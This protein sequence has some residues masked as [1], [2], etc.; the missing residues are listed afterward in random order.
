[1]ARTN[2]LR[3]G[4]ALFIGL[5]AATFGI[6]KISVSE[7]DYFDYVTVFSN[8][9]IARFTEMPIRVYISPML[10]TDVYL[11]AIRY[12]MRQWELAAG[13]II[14]FVETEDNGDADIRVSWGT[15]GLWPITEVTGAKA[16]LTRLDGDRIRV[17]IILV[18]HW[19][20]FEEVGEPGRLRAIC[21]HE[22]G[23]A[24]GL[25]G[26]S[27][28]SRDVEFRAS[29]LEHPS[30]RDI[31]T[32]RRVYATP[33]NTPQHEIAIETINQRLDGSPADARRHYL[34]GT[35]TVDK[36]DF[37]EAI[38]HFKTALALDPASE[39]AR[40]K[41]LQVYHDFGHYEQAI[42]LVKE[43]LAETPSHDVYN[44]LGVMFYRN[45]QID[46]SI[47]AFQNSVDRNSHDLAAQHNLHQIFREKG[48]AALQAANY[49]QA[50]A[51]FEK[52]LHY[53]ARD[54]SAVYRLMGDSYER[55]GEF[56]KAISHY[57][58]A[59]ETNPVNRE[60]QDALAQ[61]HNN[62]GVRLRNAKRWDDAINAYKR[63]LALAPTLAVARSN[64]IDALL[65][66]AKHH[67]AMGRLDAAIATYRELAALET[68]SSDAHSRLGE[69]YLEQEAYIKAIESFQSAYDLKPNLPQTRHNLVVAYSTYAKHLDTQSR[70]DHAIKQL[71]QALAVAPNHVNLHVSLARVYQ[72]SGDF[73]RA[74]AA[75]ARAL[76]IQPN[77]D[78]VSRES[79]SLRTIRAN[80]LLNARRYSAAL[81]E[82]EAIPPPERSVEIHN[83]IGYLYL[84]RRGFAKAVG[85]FESA[86]TIAPTNLI[87][88]QN[89]LAIESQLIRQPPHRLTQDE[90]KNLLARTQNRLAMYYLN[91]GEYDKAKVKYRAA[92][93]LSPTNAEVRRALGATGQDLAQLTGQRALKVE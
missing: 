64:L 17:E 24:I 70:H 73:D 38:G 67:R 39:P 29:A 36:G 84:I 22:F 87:A 82:F 83:S 57:R 89:L 16:E 35:I 3:L 7:D 26:H 4:V 8:G 42:E 53:A 92:M 44:T 23:H 90:I 50:D 58:K 48:I 12:G 27:P 2:R 31:K 76:Q 85:A 79:I 43:A 33:Q 15:A 10:R 18:P 49:A 9:R 20:R 56:A 80:K 19:S 91:H 61:C 32:L 41:L 37:K 63:A 52:A 68:D 78:S 5:C 93:N 86:L 47:T 28:D 88:Y 77:S 65:Q 34:L 66:R 75:F 45:G 14:E 46:E 21:L 6:A 81:T 62:H 11:N 59:L 51:Y 69:L 72:R 40:Q 74:Q 1:M 25:W 71:R 30:P 54:E 55:R 13:G 60:I